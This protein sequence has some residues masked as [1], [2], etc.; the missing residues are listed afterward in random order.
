MHTSTPHAQ[1]LY[2]RLDFFF[3]C[4]FKYLPHAFIQC[5]YF[6]SQTHIYT[7]T[8]THNHTKY[9]LKCRPT[10]NFDKS[11]SELHNCLIVKKYSSLLSLS[12][13]KK[14]Q[15]KKSKKLL[16][17]HKTH[18]NT[19]YLADSKPPKPAIKSSTLP[20]TSSQGKL[21]VVAKNH[22]KISASVFFFSFF[23]YL[24]L[25]RANLI[26]MQSKNVVMRGAV[27]RQP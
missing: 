18:A 11:Q 23:K 8:F 14:K 4:A 7:F 24:Q 9:P 15:T 19:R 5:I 25:Q 16:P 26:L 3:Q 22:N 2:I 21:K 17:N 12:S 27:Y 20:R 6:E 10:T 13:A 1:H